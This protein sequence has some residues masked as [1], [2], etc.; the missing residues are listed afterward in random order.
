[1]FFSN[2]IDREKTLQSIIKLSSIYRFI[3]TYPL[4]NWVCFQETSFSFIP[5]KL[6]LLEFFICAGRITGVGRLI[7][8]YAN[9]VGMSEDL[10]FTKGH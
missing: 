3:E 8:A 2:L 6:W 7:K 1:M 4:S 5:A 9:W 10:I